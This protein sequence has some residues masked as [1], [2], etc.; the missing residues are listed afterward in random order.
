MD[1]ALFVRG[2]DGLDDLSRDADRLLDRNGALANAL[3]ER[4]TFNQ[5]HDQRVDT[6]G[7]L[8][9]VDLRDVRVI[10]S[11]ECLGFALEPGDA[12]RIGGE[13]LW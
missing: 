3:R 13:R 12:L 11:G 2:L 4:R 7:F 5:F 10:Q 1:D 9:T 8:E 6:A